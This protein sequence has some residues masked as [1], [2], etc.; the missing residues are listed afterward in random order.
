M[1][2]SSKLLADALVR[3]KSHL[4]ESDDLTLIVLK[5]HLI[6]EE[7]INALLSDLVE[8][9]KPLIKARFSFAQRLALIE[10][11]VSRKEAQ[12]L[13]LNAA[14][15][16]NSLRNELAHNLSSDKLEK[17]LSDFLQSIE[18][19][20]DS[21]ALRE[22]SFSKRLKLGIVTVCATFTG[23]RAAALESQQ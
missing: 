14:G 13:N 23:R 16:L 9:E 12:S 8:N 22:Y 10:A 19:L 15:K 6:L 1:T 2:D 5:G 4:P 7:E 20:E 3:I 11:H 21:D 17:R 18:R